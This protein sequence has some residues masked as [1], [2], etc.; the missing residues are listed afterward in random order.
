MPRDWP[1][2]D[3]TIGVW[4]GF[5]ALWAG[6][7]TEEQPERIVAGHARDTKTINAPFQEMAR[8]GFH[9]VTWGAVSE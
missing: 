2:P 1:C 5:L 3:S 6:F 4:S 7:A 9:L 8:R